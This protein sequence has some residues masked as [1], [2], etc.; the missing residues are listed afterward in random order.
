LQ[1]AACVIEFDTF[2]EEVE[3]MRVFELAYGIKVA[4]FAR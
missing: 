4:G 2:E 3:E 1:V